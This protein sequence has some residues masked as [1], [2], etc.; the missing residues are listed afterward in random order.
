VR[1]GYE[2]TSEMDTFIEKYKNMLTE[3]NQQ[4]KF[5]EFKA[6]EKEI[7]EKNKSVAGSRK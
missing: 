7:R 5:E 4:S 3:F 2:K 1:I 6:K